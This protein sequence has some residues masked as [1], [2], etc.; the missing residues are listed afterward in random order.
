MPGLPG[1]TTTSWCRAST[2]RQRSLPPARPDDDDLHA[3]VGGELDVLVA[4]GADAEEADRH[5]DL[6]LEEGE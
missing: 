5:A 4:A 2:T 3:A 6:L 1:V